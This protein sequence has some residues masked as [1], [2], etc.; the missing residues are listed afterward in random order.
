MVL[1]VKIKA[2]F[3]IGAERLYNIKKIVK[4]RRKGNFII[5]FNDK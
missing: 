5:F 3:V 2:G 1:K 4:Y